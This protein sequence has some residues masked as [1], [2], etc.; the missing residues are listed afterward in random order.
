VKKFKPGSSVRVK[1]RA[2]VEGS[3]FTP[4][5]LVVTLQG[6]DGTPIV[7]SSPVV[8][9]TGCLQS[10]TVL[11]MSAVPGGWIARAQA[12]G[13]AANQNALKEIPFEVEPLAF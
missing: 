5:S 8:T 3:P 10:D 7:D 12:T 13:V 11:P 4:T 6:P 1:I 2:T 9:T